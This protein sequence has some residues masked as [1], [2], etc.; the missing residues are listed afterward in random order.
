M[1]A[2]LVSQQLH[3]N[4]ARDQLPDPSINFWSFCLVKLIPHDALTPL[5]ELIVTERAECSKATYR[6]SHWRLGALAQPRHATYQ[7]DSS[8][9]ATATTIMILDSSENII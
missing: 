7:Q 4:E 6:A 8:L 2:W 1:L 3:L 5:F 9:Y